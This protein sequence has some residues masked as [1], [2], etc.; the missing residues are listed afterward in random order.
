MSLL[1]SHIHSAVADLPSV[2]HPLWSRTHLCCSCTREQETSK[3]FSRCS[4]KRCM[5]WIN[6]SPL[7]NGTGKLLPVL[8]PF[9]Q[10]AGLTELS[11][12]TINI[13]QWQKITSLKR[14]EDRQGRSKPLPTTQ[15]W[16]EVWGRIKKRPPAISALWAFY[17]SI[18]CILL[19]PK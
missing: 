2:Q 11:R 9:P 5:S 7:Q 1:T 17:C 18:P 19:I 4:F 8:P 14:L 10:Q 3:I 6:T 16:D 15:H 12:N 13:P